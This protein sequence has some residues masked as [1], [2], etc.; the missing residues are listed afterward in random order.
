[1]LN[2]NCMPRGGSQVEGSGAEFLRA[3]INVSLTFALVSARLSLSFP[4]R[5]ASH[6][7]VQSAVAAFASPDAPLLV[8][9]CGAAEEEA[10]GRRGLPALVFGSTVDSLA[11]AADDALGTFPAGYVLFLAGDE[12]C[13][14]CVRGLQRADKERRHL[15][16]ILGYF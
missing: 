4:Q 1:M 16:R 8:R 11:A 13:M 5:W 6:A 2:E 12:V 14:R 9:A 10:M 15:A 3:S 7:A